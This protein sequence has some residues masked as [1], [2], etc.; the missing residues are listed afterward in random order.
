MKVTGE[1]PRDE[2]LADRAPGPATALYSDDE[3][4]TIR[5][6]GKARR[7]TELCVSCADL[8]S[9]ELGKVLDRLHADH[10]RPEI[11]DQFRRCTDCRHTLQSDCAVDQANVA[12]A[13]HEQLAVCTEK[14]GFDMPF[15]LVR[16]DVLLGE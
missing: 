3:V 14:R 5:A 11:G 1:A 10:C 9:C 4:Q 6:R 7:L 8:K 13:L 15:C 2:S 16:W 12:P